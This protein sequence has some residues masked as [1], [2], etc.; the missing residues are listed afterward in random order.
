M[1]SLVELALDGG[2]A[3]LGGAMTSMVVLAMGGS[4]GLFSG[5]DVTK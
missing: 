1:T 2:D 5:A 3:L 4:E